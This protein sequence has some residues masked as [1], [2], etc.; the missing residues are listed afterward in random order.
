[1]AQSSETAG[2]TGFNCREARLS[3]EATIGHTENPS[4]TSLGNAQEMLE[5]EARSLP[6]PKSIDFDIAYCYGDGRR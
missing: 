4:Q 6:I 2:A 3:V 1:M 5:V